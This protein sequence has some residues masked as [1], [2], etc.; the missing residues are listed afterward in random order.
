MKEI[1]LSLFADPV[2]ARLVLIAERAAAACQK[3]TTACEYCASQVDLKIGYHGRECDG[4]G[5]LSGGD[6]DR[7]S[8]AL[9]LALAHVT[10]PPFLI[11]DESLSFLDCDTKEASIKAIGIFAQQTEAAVVSIQQD[12]GSLSYDKTVDLDG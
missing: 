1:L 11:M 5:Q 10:R 3:S 8:L 7:A 2:E 6:G 9:T 4:A 12:S